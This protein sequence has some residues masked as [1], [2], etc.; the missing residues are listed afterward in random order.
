MEDGKFIREV[1]SHS[2]DA[3]CWVA[4]GD[5]MYRRINHESVAKACVAGGNVIRESRGV[6]VDIINKYGGRIDSCYFPF[7][8]KPHVLPDYKNITK[9]I[10]TYIDLFE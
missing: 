3:E 1:L 7:S 6:V 10:R 2:D 5:F 4:L 8:D 9:A